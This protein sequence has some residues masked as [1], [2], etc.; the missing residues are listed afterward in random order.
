MTMQKHSDPMD[1]RLQAAL[2]AQDWALLTRLCRQALRK[3]GRHHKAHRLLGFALSQTG[4]IDPA[5]QAFRQAAALWP[6]DAELLINYANTLLTQGRNVE[7]LPLL[8]RVVALRPHHSTCW[9]KLAQCCYTMTLNQ[10]GFDASQKALAHAKTL[11]EEL[12]ALTQSAVHRREL[13]QVRE[14][15]QD[16]ER[17]IALAPQAAHSYTNALL[18][19]L[20]DPHSQ[21]SE[22]QRL[23]RVFSDNFESPLLEQ[24]P[25]FEDKDRNPWRRLRVGF[26]SPDFRNH[27][28]MYFAEG[29]L[30]GLDRQQFE[31]IAFYNYPVE[32]HVTTRVQC[33]ADRFIKI[34]GKTP[35]Q[36]AQA[37]RDA[38]IDIAIDLAGHTGGN[39]LLALARKPAPVQLSTI[40]YPGTTGLRAIDWWVSDAV[41]DPA[42]APQW[43]TERL[44]RLPTRWACYRPMIRNPLWRYQPAYQVRPTPALAN[45]YI[46]FGSCNN[47]GKLTDEVLALWG[48]LLQAVPHSRLLIEGKNLDIETTERAYRQHC[49]D[50]GIDPERLELVAMDN[51]NQYLTYHR[52]DIALD[53]F[54]LVGGTSTNDLLWMGVPVVTLN[55]DTLRNRMGVGILAHMGCH[56]WVARDQDEYLGIAAAL[57]S[58]VTALNQLRQVLR[59]EVEASAVMREDVFVQE[60]GNALRSMWLHWLTKTEHPDW[61]QAQVDAQVQAMLDQA[62]PQPDHQ[63]FLV[64]VAPG[65]RVP[66]SIAYQRLQKMLDTAKTRHMPLAGAEGA[67]DLLANRH[68]AQA[69]ELAERILCA[70]PHDAM[71]LTVLAEIENAHGHLDFGRV[72]L[73]EA[74]QSLGER[75]PAQVLLER[76]RQY[77]QAAQDYLGEPQCPIGA[78]SALV[79]NDS[80]VNVETLVT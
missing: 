47:L 31:V 28:V 41:T 49:A 34:S 5:L 32:D 46:T 25:K 77:V 15:V 52:I 53:P 42:T 7:A 74:L 37:I 51:R 19:M 6:Q 13:G 70:K 24:W 69:T 33:H 27:A 14:A 35:E 56:N 9:A 72:Y 2:D 38:D 78:A 36:Q 26:I 54:P 59:Q 60:F 45:G 20:A 8:E 29:L 55:G 22:L 17:A 73:K 1:A 21:A 40:G 43:Y 63:E 67:S 4:D 58:D 76:T 18:F 61:T 65:E 12:D 80:P 64:G 39:T 48:R 66:L 68:W 62:P 57:A 3:N 11:G 16:C 44:Y 50:L 30:A 23:A 75:E 71:A 79:R 10:K